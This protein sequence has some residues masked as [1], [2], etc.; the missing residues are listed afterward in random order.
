MKTLPESPTIK[1]VSLPTWQEQLP[2]R[3]RSRRI[4]VRCCEDI[5]S[6]KRRGSESNE[7]FI[8]NQPP[9]PDF[10]AVFTTDFITQS[11]R[12][13]LKVLAKDFRILNLEV[14]S[15]KHFPLGHVIPVEHKFPIEL[16]LMAEKFPIFVFQFI[17]H[18]CSRKN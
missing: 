9:Y 12:K 1:N 3:V 14:F 16:N 7:V 6:N 18:N 8:D 13:S 17:H 4:W 11:L 10:Q 15:D 2:R 5:L